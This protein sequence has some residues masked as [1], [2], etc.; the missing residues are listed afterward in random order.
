MSLGI[1]TEHD[2]DVAFTERDGCVA[3]MIQSDKS[4]VSEELE[5]VKEERDSLLEKVKELEEKIERITE[6]E[7]PETMGAL[8]V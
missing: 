2:Y 7:S 1:C 3:C 5:T 6:D 8:Q 4:E